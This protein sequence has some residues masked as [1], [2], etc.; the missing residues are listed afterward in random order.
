VR[1]IAFESLK[2]AQ[3]NKIENVTGSILLCLFM[4]SKGSRGVW[5]KGGVNG[6]GTKWDEKEWK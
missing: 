6:Q 2:N 1:V 4:D 3:N 5:I